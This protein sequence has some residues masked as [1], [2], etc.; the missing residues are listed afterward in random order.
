MRLL[1]PTWHYSSPV[2]ILHT[3]NSLWSGTKSM[4]R[5]EPMRLLGPR[6]CY[7]SPVIVCTYR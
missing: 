6:W 5:R 1:G 4:R 2:I 3:R 7:S